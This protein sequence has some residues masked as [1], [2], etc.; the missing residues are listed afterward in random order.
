MYVFSLKMSNMIS[1]CSTWYWFKQSIY[2]LSSKISTCNRKTVFANNICYFYHLLPQ[3]AD[4]LNI[5]RALNYSMLFKKIPSENHPY[6][7]LIYQTL[8]FHKLSNCILQLISKNKE[9][10]QRTRECF[11]ILSR[12]VFQIKHSY[13]WRVSETG[14]FYSSKIYNYSQSNFKIVVRLIEFICLFN[15]LFIYLFLDKC[16]I[17]NIDSLLIK[18]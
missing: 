9:R 13:I 3:F 1:V 17:K 16:R 6:L 4:P 7:F 2:K 14:R 11:M 15:N 10:N 12:R 8:W 5:S 18:I